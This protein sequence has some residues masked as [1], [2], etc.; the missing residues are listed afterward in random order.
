MNQVRSRTH[1]SMALCLSLGCFG[2]M[3][4]TASFIQSDKGFQ[5]RPGTFP[6]EVFV[7]QAPQTRFAPVGIVE[8]RG[9]VTVPAANLMKAAVSEGTALGCDVLVHQALYEQRSGVRRRHLNGVASWLFTCGVLDPAKPTAEGERLADAT[10][11]EI[12]QYEFGEPVCDD[13]DPTG[14]HI[15]NTICRLYGHYR[16]WNDGMVWAPWVH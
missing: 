5:A 1:L 3:G 7:D 10:L 15:P 9:P 11:K 12:I 6:P 8:A 4:T 13:E 14:S 16:T 2:C